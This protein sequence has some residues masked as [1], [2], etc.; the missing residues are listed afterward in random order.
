MRFPTSQSKKRK[1]WI[2]FTCVNCDKTS[3]KWYVAKTWDCKCE[4]CK[5]GGYTIQDFLNKVKEIH[6]ETY[7]YSK[8]VYENKRTPVTIIC[9]EHGEFSQRPAEHFEGHG[10]NKCGN[11]TIGNKQ[12]LDKTIWLE[13]ILKYPLISFIDENQIISYH[14]TVDLTC[15]IHGNFTTTLGSIGVLTYLCS[16]CARVSHQF[17]SVR[18]SLIGQQAT[19]YYVYLPTIDMYKLGVTINP[20]KTRLHGLEYEVLLE[21]QIEYYQG[22]KIE[23]ELHTELK[24]FRYQGTK[25]LLS[26]GGNTELYKTDIYYYLIGALHQ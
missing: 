10:C 7:C 25:R 24:D 5:K 22:L 9:K 1:K 18:P 23:H 11:I 21:Q 26:I 20:I 16:E 2:T 4:H 15:N 14:Q 6:G 13:R 12:L 19:L 3:S 17:Q 8:V